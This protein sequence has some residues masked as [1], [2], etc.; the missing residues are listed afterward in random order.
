MTRVI[1]AVARLRYMPLVLKMATPQQRSWCVLQL[2]KKE[3][4][5]AVQRAF[6]SQFHTE[7]PSRVSIYAWYKKFEHKGCICKDKSPG[8]PSV[9]D[10][11]VD[12]V[13]ACFQRSPQKSTRRASRELQLPQTTISKILRK[14]LLM[15]P[16]KLQLVRALKPE[17][18]AD[19]RLDIC[20]VTRGAHIESL[21]GV[22]KT[23]SVFLSTGVGVKF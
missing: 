21:W 6:R 18:L 8:R 4:V 1:V 10:E 22:Y 11:A 17:D 20:R 9:S 2:A 16:Y 7:P 5:T 15:K 19:Y 12:R 14:P 13:R 23:L 3:S